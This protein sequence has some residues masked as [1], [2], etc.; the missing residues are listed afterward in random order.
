[1]EKVAINAVMAGCRPEYMPL[2]LA[3][4]E[5]VAEPDFGIQDVGSTVGLTPLIILNGPIVKQLKFNSGQGVL[6]PQAQA[7]ITVGR[8]L[9]LPR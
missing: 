2:L 4:T 3:I 9:R 6:R 1:M 7:N 8:L 5:A